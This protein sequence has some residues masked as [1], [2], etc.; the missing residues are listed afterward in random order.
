M[1]RHIRLI[2]HFIRASLQQEMAYSV[3]FFINVLTS[4]LT[5]IT[6]IVGISILF[7]QVEAVRGWT[8]PSALV[9]LG[10]FLTMSALRALFISPSLDSLAGMGGDVWTGKLDYVL[11][12][13]VDV[14]FLA[15]FRQWRPYALFD[16]LLG[17]GVTITAAAKLD[18]TLSA[19]QIASFLLM[20]A[21]GLLTLYAVLLAFAGLVFWSPGFLFGWV[22]DGVFQMARYPISLY[23]GWVGLV[24]T[25]II[26]VGVMTTIPVQALTGSLPLETAVGAA[27]LAVIGFA[28]GT[29]LFRAGVRRYASASS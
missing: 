24:L 12:R 16:L 28:G 20:L 4:T 21:V 10:I 8:Y 6:G 18:A 23:P 5:L 22:F 13:P 27:L 3:N 19:A 25:W 15:S 7:H 26:P 14:Q 9:I 2:G 1:T 17:V 11:L 29:A